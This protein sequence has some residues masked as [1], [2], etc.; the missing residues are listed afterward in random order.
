MSQ[1]RDG[2]DEAGSRGD[3][4]ASRP[5]GL[6]VAVREEFGEAT[7]LTAEGV[8]SMTGNGDDGWTLHL[9]VVEVPR[10]PDTTSLLATYEVTADPGGRLTGYR[11]IRRY[12]RG[13]PDP[14]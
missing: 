14:R 6:S 13:R 4:G 1:N 12:E 8:T 9:E 10:V 2:K 5:A 3:R 7:G 11:R